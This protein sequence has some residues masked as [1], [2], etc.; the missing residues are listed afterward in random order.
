M[1]QRRIERQGIRKNQVGAQLSIK[2]EKKRS[3]T[4][5]KAVLIY[6]FYRDGAV[7]TEWIRNT[8]WKTGKK[9]RFIKM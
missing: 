8:S 1:I 5:D 7:L 3:L 4:T 6:A 2:P 9:K